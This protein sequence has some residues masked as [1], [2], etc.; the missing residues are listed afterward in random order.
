MELQLDKVYADRNGV[1]W[2]VIKV[3]GPAIAPVTAGRWEG[4]SYPTRTFQRDGHYW[5]DHEDRWD[6][7]EEVLN[8][9]VQSTDS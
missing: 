9:R 4:R 8:G 6:L 7:I 2:R 1:E 5:K 3:D